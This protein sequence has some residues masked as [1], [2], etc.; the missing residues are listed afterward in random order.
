[1]CS[2]VKV[3]ESASAINQVIDKLQSIGPLRVQRRRVKLFRTPLR[4]T[5]DN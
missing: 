2:E 4:I 3:E 1:M 5:E